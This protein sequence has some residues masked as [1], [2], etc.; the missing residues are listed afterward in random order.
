MRKVFEQLAHAPAVVFDEVRGHDF[1][2]LLEPPQAYHGEQDALAGHAVG[3]YY[4]E[5]GYAVGRDYK[6]LVAQ[7]EV[8]AHFSL[9]DSFEGKPFDGH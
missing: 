8:F 6:E 5:R 3:H 2:R 4:V 1:S 9:G 7:V